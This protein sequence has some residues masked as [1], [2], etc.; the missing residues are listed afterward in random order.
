[1]LKN[2]GMV[3]YRPR[4][5]FIVRV[6]SHHILPIPRRMPGLDA[7]YIWNYPFHHPDTVRVILIHIPRFRADASTGIGTPTYQYTIRLSKHGAIREIG[8]H[9][10]VL[11]ASSSSAGLTLPRCIGLMKRSVYNEGRLGVPDI[12]GVVQPLLTVHSASC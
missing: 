5:S 3:Y 6:I 1:M 4:R 12:L 2:I 10:R 9:H 7:C 8:L 11:K